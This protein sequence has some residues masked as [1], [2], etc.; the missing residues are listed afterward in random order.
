MKDMFIKID[1]ERTE[2][3]DKVSARIAG[4]LSETAFSFSRMNISLFTENF[5]KEFI[6][7]Q[8]E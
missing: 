7:T 2:E 6:I 1:D 8:V 4:V 3:A 5:F